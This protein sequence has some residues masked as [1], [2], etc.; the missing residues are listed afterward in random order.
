MPPDEMQPTREASSLPT[1]YHR[2]A[3][4]PSEGSARVF[5]SQLRLRQ[6]LLRSMLI[7][8][9][10]RL[11]RTHRGEQAS[12]GPCR[13]MRRRLRV[14]PPA[15][16][17]LPSTGLES[18]RLPY[19]RRFRCLR[20][21]LPARRG[22]WDAQ[23]LGKPHARHRCAMLKGGVRHVI[24]PFTFID[25]RPSRWFCYACALSWTRPR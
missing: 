10:R 5:L 17:S 24:L 16:D 20:A 2:S 6:S 3:T 11:G 22:G 9:F 25:S 18:G 7:Q 14:R 13:L 1:P 4:I 19:L 8:V 23:H 12:L 21:G 15:N